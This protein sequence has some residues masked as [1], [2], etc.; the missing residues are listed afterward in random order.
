MNNMSENKVLALS[1][2]VD[3]QDQS[4]PNMLAWIDP[5]LAWLL[6]EIDAKAEFDFPSHREMYT[7][8][9]CSNASITIKPTD[10]EYADKMYTAGQLHLAAGM[11]EESVKCGY[12][13]LDQ[14]G[15]QITY[16]DAKESCGIK[17]SVRGYKANFSGSRIDYVDSIANEIRLITMIAICICDIIRYNKCNDDY[18]EELE[19]LLNKEYDIL[20]DDE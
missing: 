6:H 8:A 13:S 15:I 20:K 7:T 9:D 5:R 10:N 14:A 18:R 12:M 1:S 17:V 16:L 4:T 2:D 11:I 3:M 19:F